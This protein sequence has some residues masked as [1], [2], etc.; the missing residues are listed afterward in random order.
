MLSYLW[1]SMIDV[2]SI[3]MID[4]LAWSWILF[5]ESNV[6][7][8]HHNDLVVRNTMSMNNLIR[9]TNIS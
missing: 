2:S 6:V 9:V 4:D 1:H 3:G 7:I 5:V 8:H